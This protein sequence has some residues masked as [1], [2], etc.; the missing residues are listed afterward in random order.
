L[1]ALVQR[2]DAEYTAK[3]RAALGDT[4]QGKAYQ[5]VSDARQAYAA[6]EK[7]LLVK[8]F[9]ELKPIVGEERLM[10]KAPMPP[11]SAR[12]IAPPPTTPAAPGATATPSAAP[13]AK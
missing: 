1:E 5:A 3:V 13:Q 2:T 8:L 10:P 12:P 7:A 4:P 9:G 6:Q 11:R